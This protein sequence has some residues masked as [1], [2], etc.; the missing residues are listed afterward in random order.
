MR[1][2]GDLERED[3]VGSTHSYRLDGL[4]RQPLRT[5]GITSDVQI[6]TLEGSIGVRVNTPDGAPKKALFV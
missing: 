5:K 4:I 3:F 2:G 1:K 6:H